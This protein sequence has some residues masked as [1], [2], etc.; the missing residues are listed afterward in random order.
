MTSLAV[1]TETV[2]HDCNV[3]TAEMRSQSRLARHARPRQIAMYL[4]RKLTSRS[5]PEIGR[6]FGGR[7]H[8]T[9]LH[10]YRRIEHL[11]VMDDHMAAR[12]EGLRFKLLSNP[13]PSNPIVYRQHLKACE[14][15]GLGLRGVIA[16]AED[17]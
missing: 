3:T 17:V 1:I 10:G 15:I 14:S 12:V 11:I 4:A 16:Y 8:T 6:Y 13:N 7:D 9:A 2:G 5:Y